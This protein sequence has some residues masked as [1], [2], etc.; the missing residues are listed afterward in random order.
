[1]TINGKRSKKDL[2]KYYFSKFKRRNQEFCERVQDI[3]PGGGSFC[4][5]G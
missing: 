3:L 2:K 1:M 4:V 5:G